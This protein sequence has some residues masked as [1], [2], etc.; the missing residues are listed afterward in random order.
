MKKKN[1]I[2][3]L[4]LQHWARLEREHNDGDNDNDGDNHNDDGD[5]NP[6]DDRDID[7]DNKKKTDK[8]ENLKTQM[9]PDKAATRHGESVEPAL[10]VATTA[11]IGNQG[12]CTK[13][14]RFPLSIISYLSYIWPILC[15]Q[16]HL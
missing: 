14:R 12:R 2:L 8:H 16:W 6:H 15:R 9:V 13:K 3:N 11:M 4:W 1:E 10:Q 7:D 5:G